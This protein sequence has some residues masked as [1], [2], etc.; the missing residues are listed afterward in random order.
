MLWSSCDDLATEKKDVVRFDYSIE[1]DSTS[2]IQLSN[3]EIDPY[4]TEELDEYKSQRDKVEDFEIASV[5]FR[6]YTFRADDDSARHKG[7]A[8]ITSD[9]GTTF[10]IEMF[11]VGDEYKD[12]ENHE[13]HMLR[14]N[15]KEGTEAYAILSDEVLKAD[16]FIIDM[17]DVWG[18]VDSL[19][20][21]MSIY[22]HFNITSQLK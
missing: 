5:E 6:M 20:C 3:T 8:T 18:V 9:P 4:T 15:G 1:A 13:V 7:N 21:D 10:E 17:S 19:N 12:T 22:I 14:L 2:S 11:D 16:K